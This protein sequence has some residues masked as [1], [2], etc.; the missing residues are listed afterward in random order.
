MQLCSEVVCLVYCWLPSVFM[1]TI[2]LFIQLE[3]IQ[4]LKTQVNIKYIPSRVVLYVVY[5]K[6][7]AKLTDKL[8]VF[9]RGACFHVA[10]ATKREIDISCSQSVA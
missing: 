6:S 7:H 4:F 9:V 5:S 1:F 2:L 8:S 3:L 10:N